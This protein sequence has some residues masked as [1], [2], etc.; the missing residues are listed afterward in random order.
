MSHEDAV[1]EFQAM[2]DKQ[3][4]PDFAKHTNIV[5]LLNTKGKQ[6]FIPS[7]W[8]GIEAPEIELDISNDIPRDFRT[9]RRNVNPKIYE[10]AKLE[11]DRLSQYFYT[12]STSPYAHPLVIA[13]KATKPFIRFCGSYD[14]FANK[15]ILP[16]HY[17]IP[18]VPE[19]IQ[20]AQ[21][22]KYFIDLDLQNAFHQ[23]RI[24]PKTRRLLAVQTPWGLYEPKFLPEGVG[25]ASPYLQ[26][27]VADI[28]ADM[29]DFTITIFDN[30]LICANTYD[31]LYANFER[32]LD[33]CI[34]RNVY[35]KFSK[36]WLG[37]TEATFFGYKVKHNGY[38]LTQERK[39][40]ILNIA[41]P[42]NLKQAQVFFG[43]S[44]FFRSFVPNYTTAAQHLHDLLHKDFKWDP[45]QWQHDYIQEFQAFKQALCDACFLHFPDYTLEWVTRVDSS[46]FGVGG[47]I[48]QIVP[49]TDPNSPPTYQPI[50]FIS[51][52]YTPLAMRW[53]TIEKERY[54]CYI[55]VK[56]SAHLLMGKRFILETDHA[57]LVWMEKS[58]VPKIIRWRMYLQS[59]DFLIRHIPGKQNIIADWFSRLYHSYTPFQLQSLLSLTVNAPVTFIDPTYKCHQLHM[60]DNIINN[61]R[62]QIF[63]NE[64]IDTTQP[65]LQ[66]FSNLNASKLFQLLPDQ[67]LAAVHNSK[68]G[69]HGIHRTY[70]LLNKHYP[71]HKIPLK[72]ITDYIHACPACQ[73][74]RLQHVPLP[75]INRVLPHAH[76]RS[77]LGVDLVTLRPD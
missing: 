44:V 18:H 49:S 19:M 26:S 37:I 12:P 61:H 59:Y 60:L 76:Q 8:S 71:G 53:S 55:T 48:L 32:I 36:T 29:S 23:V 72:L 35:C 5:N 67:A 33:R 14:L 51:H 73:K 13:P 45:G 57:N 34:Q 56:L 21:G 54:S 47:V 28:F 41:F 4:Q 77:T 10:N 3:I 75:P 46:D 30:I 40:A 1:L 22:F 62:A 39:D 58:T 9:A 6:V 31:E 38:E 11:F 27:V 50:A 65:L 74:H 63:A 52:K 66:F 68:M 70:N 15:H 25:P 16:Y 7:S 43:S 69:H 17:P 2:F 42:K 64:S 24:G 20:K